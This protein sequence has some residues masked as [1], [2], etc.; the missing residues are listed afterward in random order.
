MTEFK[1]SRKIIQSLSTLCDNE[2][3]TVCSQHGK[4][5]P[6]VKK[7]VDSWKAEETFDHI[8]PVALPSQDAVLEIIQKARSI[9]FPGY[10]TKTKLHQSN[11]E[12]FIGQETTDLYEMLVEQISMAIR[13]NCRRN[14]LPCSNCD[15]MSH[16]I[17][18]NFIERLPKVT[19][20]LTADIHS[21]L[22][23]D[24]ATKS[25]DEVI[26]CY[27]GLLATSIFRLA[28]ELNELAVP[29]IPRIMTEYAHSQTGIDIHPGATIGPGLFID[30][31]TGVV[32]GETTIIGNDVRIYQ[33]VTLGALSL[34]RDAGEKLYQKKRHPTIE[35]DV[36][37]YS[38]TT[39]LGG[40]TVIGKGAVIG[41][42][43][44]LTE[45]VEAGTKVLLKKPELIY[46]GSG[47]ISEMTRPSAH[48]TTMAAKKEII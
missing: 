21:T 15:E 19:A 6:V 22:A 10:F 25:P 8:S 12:Y 41:G 31:G 24:P 20:L 11:L 16:K 40:Q 2:D 44:W 48:E 39:I 32:I 23:G 18:F 26:F 47:K 9:L 3:Q 33:G 5:P 42:N 34:P 17:A 35:D 13:H 1:E 7:L 46:S 38:N 27:P 29:I 43:I 45:S 37:I 36:I 14:D 4:I 30:H 28:H